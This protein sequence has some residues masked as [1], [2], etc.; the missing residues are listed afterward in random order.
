VLR[1]TGQ[2]PHVGHE[3]GQIEPAVGG[4]QPG[5]FHGRRA[6]LAAG[7]PVPLLASSSTYVPNANLQAIENKYPCILAGT[8]ERFFT[9]RMARESAETGND[10]GGFALRLKTR[11]ARPN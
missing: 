5:P 10:A 8:L 3:Q 4:F 9:F 7:N 11:L 6:E 1:N 2:A